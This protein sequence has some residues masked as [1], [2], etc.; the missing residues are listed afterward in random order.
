MT[1]LEF[2]KG[3]T[4]ISMTYQKFD[5]DTT[6]MDIWY[7]F[8]EEIRADIF[9][10]AVK[11]FI[12]QSKFAPTV[13]DLLSLCEEQQ[14]VII[15]ET[16]KLMWDRGYFTQK[17]VLTEIQA[18]RN[19]EKANHWV[20]RKIIPDWFEADMKLYE[21]FYLENKQQLKLGGSKP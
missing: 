10:M 13:T 7:S 12:R 5:M 8:F 14:E 11:S 3:M 15:N 6:M 19:F 16:L 18:M 1:Q 17:G 9:I 21:Q 4:I 2:T 20:E